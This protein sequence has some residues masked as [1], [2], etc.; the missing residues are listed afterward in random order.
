MNN[1]AVL[2]LIVGLVGGNAAVAE[3]TFGKIPSMV[4]ALNSITTNQ[5]LTPARVNKGNADTIAQSVELELSKSLESVS[6]A[7]DRQ[8]EEKFAQQLTG[9]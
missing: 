7:L 4:L 9:Q 2:A 3:D 8:L 5:W 6:I 1:V